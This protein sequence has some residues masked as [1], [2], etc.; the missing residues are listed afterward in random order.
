MWF[1][2]GVGLEAQARSASTGME[3]AGT[4][5]VAPQLAGRHVLVMGRN[6]ARQHLRCACM[7]AAV[8][9]VCVRAT[10][11]VARVSGERRAFGA[12]PRWSG[13]LDGALGGPSAPP[14]RRNSTEQIGSGTKSK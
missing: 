11:I 7:R 2:G 1:V 5:A 4:F 9:A 13:R 10:A 12:P 14:T 3:R 6:P 8:S